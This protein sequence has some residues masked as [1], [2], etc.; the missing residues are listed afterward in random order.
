MLRCDDRR[1]PIVRAAV[2]I[3]EKHGGAELARM[4]S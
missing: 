1:I 3:F 2:L 4:T